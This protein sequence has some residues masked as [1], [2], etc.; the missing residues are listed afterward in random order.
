MTH[1]SGEP[2]GENVSVRFVEEMTGFISFGE[3]DFDRGVRAGRAS[4]TRLMVHLMI[5]VEDLGRFEADPMREARA[6]GWVRCDALGGQLAIEVGSF[7]LLVD[8]ASAEEKR[9]LYRLLIRDGVDHPLTLTGVKTVGRGSVLRIWRDT[10]TLYTRVLRGHVDSGD[11]PDA[12]LV[13]SGILRLHPFGFL[14]QL[15]TFRATAPS[16][17]TR[18][19]AIGRFDALFAAQLWSIYGPHARRLIARIRPHRGAGVQG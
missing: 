6:K 10:S 8:G 14:R 17:K 13:A 5:E 3:P 18:I 4:G 19:A 7:N 9:M 1:A 11:E 16:L 12:E 2:V 15:A